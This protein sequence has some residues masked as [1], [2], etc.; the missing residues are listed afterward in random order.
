M[1][2]PSRHGKPADLQQ[3][4]R[5]SARACALRAIYRTHDRN[6]VALRAREKQGIRVEPIPPAVVRALKEASRIELEASASADPDSRSVIDSLL[7][8]RTRVAAYSVQ[9]DEAVLKVCHG[10]PGMDP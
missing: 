6:A 10:G 4:V 5:Q 9:A 7:A 2:D 8:Y 1:L 3:I